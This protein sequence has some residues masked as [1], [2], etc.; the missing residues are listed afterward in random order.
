MENQRW[1]GQSQGR[2]TGFWRKPGLIQTKMAAV[3]NPFH[4][5]SSL[6]LLSSSLPS[7]L[8]PSPPFLPPFTH[9]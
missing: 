9:A 4:V 5:P 3:H 8:S 2:P 7:F 6:S 1:F